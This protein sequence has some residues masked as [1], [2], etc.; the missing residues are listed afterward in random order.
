MRRWKKTSK[1]RVTGLCE[2]NSPAIG[3]FL[4]QRTSNAKN[5]S[6]WWRHHNHPTVICCLFPGL[7]RSDSYLSSVGCLIVWFLVWFVTRFAVGQV[8]IIF[9]FHDDVIKWKHSVSRV[10]GPLWGESTADRWI[11]FTKASDAELRWSVP[12][13]TIEQTMDTQVIWDAIVLIM[14]SM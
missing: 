12:E 9:W 14:T 10:T 5:V 3:E 2:G 4:A 11:P 7:S 8:L 13:L 6:I 1:L